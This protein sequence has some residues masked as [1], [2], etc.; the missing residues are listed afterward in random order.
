MLR[1]IFN[2][3]LLRY[4]I[5]GVSSTIVDW[6]IYWILAI[7]FNVHYEL[8]LVIAFVLSSFLNYRMNKHYTFNNHSK[9]HITQFTSYFLLVILTLVL[10]VLLLHYFVGHLGMHKMTARV[11]TTCALAVS[12]YLLNKAIPF[13][14]RLFKS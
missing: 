11:V 1:L 13:N 7:E 8:A 5:T 3:E 2:K 14:H 12:N 10:S 6:I 9:K 4:T